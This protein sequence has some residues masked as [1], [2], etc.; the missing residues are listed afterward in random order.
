MAGK[1]TFVAGEILTAADVNS[2]LMDQSVQVYDDATARDTA[3]PSPLQGQL[4]YLK[5]QDTVQ[6][7]DGSNF[8]PVGGLVEVKSAL[9]T[10]IQSASVTAGDNVSVTNLSI[11]HAM[12]NASNKLIITAYMGVA[13]SS[14]GVSDVG[15]AVAD[16]TTLIGI[17][18]ASLS[19]TRVG[20]GGRAQ[21][22]AGTN[23][24]T[25]PSVTFVYQPGT[26]ASKTYTVRAINISNA[27][28]TLF[29]NRSELDT[30][31]QFNSRAASSLVIQEV[32]V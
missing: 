26:T 12:Q 11:T 2:F 23:V 24:V 6:K 3:L 25:M 29:I 18:N 32:A 22:T 16:G 31:A 17:G 13:A 9:F 14:S 5:D 8:L 4:V 15:I 10:G 27:T 21:G 19:R 7:F 1:K 20:A 28:R 30:D